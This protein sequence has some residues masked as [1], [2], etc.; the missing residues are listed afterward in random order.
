MELNIISMCPLL[1]VFNMP[2]SLA[3]YRDVLG[4]EVVSDS[5]NG[6]GSSWVWL[7]RRDDIN[8]MLNDQYEPGRVPAAP[9]AERTVWHGDTCLYFGCSD[10]DA[11]YRSLKERGLEV[12]PPKVAPY[13]MKQLYMSDPDNYGICLQWPSGGEAG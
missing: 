4:F 5:G 9:P 2:R 1:Q 3:F 13:G 8:L 7:R 11:A 10:I 6:D 12:E